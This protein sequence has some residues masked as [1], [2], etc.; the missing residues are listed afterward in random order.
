VAIGAKLYF[1]AY[2]DTHGRELWVSDGTEAGTALLKDIRS[3]WSSSYPE[4]FMVSSDGSTLYFR[5]NDIELWQSDG[6]EDGTK[7]VT[8]PEE[9][10]RRIRSD[11]YTF[12]ELGGTLYYQAYDAAHGV[13]LWKSDGTDTGTQMLKD[14][15]TSN[16][17]SMGMGKRSTGT[18][19]AGD[20]YYFIATDA[21][22]GSGLWQS[23]GTA[24]GTSMIKSQVDQIYCAEKTLYFVSHA[25]LPVT[26]KLA[27]AASRRARMIGPSGDGS[28]WTLDPAT[29]HAQLLQ[30]SI[31]EYP[32]SIVVGDQLYF[33][34]KDDTHGREL[35]VSDGTVDGTHITKDITVGRDN[36]RID[37]MTAA[38]DRLYFAADSELWVS[39]GTEAGTHL[40]KDLNPDS[41]VESDPRALTV[42]GDLLYFMATTT[43]DDRSLCVTNGTEAGTSIASA[44]EGK[45]PA[46]SSIGIA[47][48]GDKLFL[49]VV[50][51][52]DKTDLWVSDGTEAGT[53]VLIEDSEGPFIFDFSFFG[54]TVIVAAA[55]DNLFF[56]IP[57]SDDGSMEIW[58][59]DGTSEGTRKVA[60]TNTG[61]YPLPYGE[62]A[63][64]WVYYLYTA[65]SMKLYK[66][67]GTT[68]EPTLLIE[69]SW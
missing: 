51:P 19:R 49:S 52:D 14:I 29:G 41:L 12:A 64:E 26:M 56:T 13:E 8:N 23:D 9:G 34:S 28:L 45:L 44:I 53:K 48:A 33:V 30:R 36:T 27:G 38:G 16:Q 32:T 11:E 58:G 63:G 57:T 1:T 65:D 20:H 22:L 61:E 35:W 21:I 68:A 25:N 55:G 39:D 2:D 4:H 18:C 40:V 59:T 6:T 15:A 17:G 69:N 31:I 42:V 3:G 46:D 10:Y 5:A 54:R 67:N 66:T 60:T 24:E 62:Y 7:I 47:S 50:K 37:H 43:D